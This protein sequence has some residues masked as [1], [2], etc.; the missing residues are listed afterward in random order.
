MKLKRFIPS[1]IVNMFALSLLLASCASIKETP[2]PSLKPFPGGFDTLSHSQEKAL[3]W[4]TFFKSKELDTLIN[5][6][7]AENLD[8]KSG[9]QKV[10]IAGANLKLSKAALLPSVQANIS[11]GLDRYGKYTMDGVGNYDTNFSGNISR[12]QRIPS[13]VPDYFAGF[14][15][16]WEIDVWGK[17]SKR[18]EAAYHRYL[19]SASGLKWYRTQLTCQVA[20]LYYELIALDKRLQ[21]LKSNI[22]LQDK[23]LET[24]EAQM[25]GGRATALAVSQFKAQRTATM[26]KQF[27]IRQ[28]IRSVENDLNNL[29]G[30]FAK[31][32]P[33]DTALISLALPKEVYVGLPAEVILNR[34]DVKEAE[35]QL[36]AAKADV[37]AARKAFL[38]SLTLD[39][40]AGYNAFRLPLLFSPGSLAAGLVGGLTAPVLNRATL[41]NAHLVASAS[42]LD[43]YYQYQKS[44]INGYQEITRQLAALNNYKEAYRFKTIEVAELKK[45]VSTANDLYLAG[46]ASYLEVIVA[47]S[48]VLNAEMEQVDLKQASYAALIGLYRATGG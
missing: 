9:L 30:Q 40:Y 16:S 26:G 21:I 13:P 46:Y 33:R 18:K 31:K 3:S 24:V 11:A 39:A 15:S 27:E 14:R 36:K 45:A 6:A 5:L 2:V 28:Q 10:L 35:E 42:Q 8:L 25:A 7:L 48:S 41:K 32:I 1:A 20:A 34:P 17:L 47:Q 19:A 4:H 29:L 43:A 37:S 38:P 22:L 23:G 44:L 12:D